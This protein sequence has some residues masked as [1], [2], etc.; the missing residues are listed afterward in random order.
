[1]L[2]PEP[3]LLPSIFCCIGKLRF[4]FRLEII[5]KIGLT[6]IERSGKPSSTKKRFEGL[7]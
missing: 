1:M 7:Q 3:F 6:P 2:N 5:N 4:Q